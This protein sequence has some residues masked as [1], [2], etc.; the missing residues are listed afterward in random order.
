MNL[1]FDLMI[2]LVFLFC[3]WRGHKKG[4]IKSF[5]G[6]FGS[7]AAFILSS[8]LS[9]PVGVFL[10]ERFISPVMEKYLLSALS[11]RIGT[12]ADGL[13]LNAL[14]A[15]CNDILSRF[16]V[17]AESIKEKLASEGAAVGQNAID[18]L[19]EAVI[20]PV[21]ESIG[22][23]VAYI[24]LFIVL[25]I[26]IRIAI[27]ALDLVA[28]LPILNFSNKTLG[29]LM[30]AVWG[31]FLAIVFSGVLMYLEPMMQGSENDFL[32]A[33]DIEQT[34]LIRLLS[35]IDLLGIFAIK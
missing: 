5:F 18:K 27:K 8:L 3:L 10:A 1:I 15:S 6:F 19:S 28:K 11:E 34:Y 2:F 4:F 32:S 13:D 7:I 25:S 17:S 29:V 21:S 12:T 23:A 33:F 16:G 14:P 20:R 22:S 30:G 31:L 9:R 26:A 24:V 35:K